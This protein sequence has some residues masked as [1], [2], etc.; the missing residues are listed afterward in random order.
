MY[1][2]DLSVFHDQKGHFA[3]PT[4]KNLPQATHLILPLE[5][6][7]L[8]KSQFKSFVSEGGGRGIECFYFLYQNGSSP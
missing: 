6:I 2:S 4:Q 1:I 7:Y 3:E 8:E 5:I